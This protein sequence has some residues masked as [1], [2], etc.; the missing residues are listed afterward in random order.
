MTRKINT[1][2][3]VII[4]NVIIIYRDGIKNCILHV[5]GILNF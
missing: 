3:L 2:N 1:L 5:N 4:Q